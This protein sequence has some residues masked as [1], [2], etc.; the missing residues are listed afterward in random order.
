MKMPIVEMLNKYAKSNV[1]RLHMPGHKGKGLA[2]NPKMDITE[3]AFS[4]NLMNPASVILQSQKMFANEWNA[5]YAFYTVNGST[6]GIFAMIANASGSI[7]IQRSSHIAV[8]N[9]IKTFGKKAYVIND[10]D[11]DLLPNNI[12]A[13]DLEQAT[14]ENPDIKTWLVTSPSY[15][16]KILDL[17]NIRKKANELGVTVFVDSAHGAHFGLAECLPK[18]AHIYADAAVISTHKTLSA[19]TQTAVLLTNNEKLSPKLKET[20][21]IF[22][23]TSPSYLL[24]ASIDYARA[25]AAEN[26][27]GYQKL[28]G[29]VQKFFENLPDGIIGEMSDDF[30]RIVL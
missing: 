26:K 16:G 3:L 6:A 17:P 2:V 1:V 15:Y 23:T 25:Y 7:L 24:L 18:P 21:N 22:S 11:I 20:L 9:A 8:Y 29:E 5:E 28:Y 14:K 12:T 13:L 30:S 19:F 10:Y 4:D 27:N